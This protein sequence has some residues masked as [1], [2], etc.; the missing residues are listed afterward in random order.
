VIEEAARLGVKNIWL[1]PGLITKKLWSLLKQGV[2]CSSG[3]RACGVEIET[4]SFATAGLLVRKAHKKCKLALDESGEFYGVIEYM[5]EN[6]MLMA[7]IILLW[8][9]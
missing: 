6:S 4:C 2:E 9:F 5:S 8:E 1:Q 7:S 3:V